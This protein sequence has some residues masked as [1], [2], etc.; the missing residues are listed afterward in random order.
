MLTSGNS[1]GMERIPDNW[2]TRAR[3]D[4]YTV[5][6]L[7]IDAVVMALEHLEF[8]TIGGNTGTTDSFVGIDP[9]NITSG[10]YNA[11]T[12]LEGNNLFCYACKSSFPSFLRMVFTRDMYNLR[13]ASK[14]RRT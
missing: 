12:L 7:A 13:E 9:A 11:P 3:G 14:C 2:Y 1:E 5:P 6:F 8:L 4:E 10:I